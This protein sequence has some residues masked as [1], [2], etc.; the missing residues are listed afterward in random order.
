MTLM[1]KR[2][3]NDV[4]EHYPFIKIDEITIKLLLSNCLHN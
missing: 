4:L 3:I 1:G 2:K